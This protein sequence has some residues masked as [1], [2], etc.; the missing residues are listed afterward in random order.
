ML[1]PSRTHSSKTG[2]LWPLG[3]VCRFTHWVCCHQSQEFPDRPRLTRA[4][5]QRKGDR[6]DVCVEVALPFQVPIS[7]ITAP[8]KGTAA[9]A[10]AKLLQSCSTLCDAIDGSPLGSPVPGILQARTVSGL[11]LPSPMHEREKGK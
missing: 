4:L 10:A 3:R 11:P 1:H 9:A 2:A 5:L 7:G 6:K 8:K